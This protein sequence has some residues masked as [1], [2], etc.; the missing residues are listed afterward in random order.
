MHLPSTGSPAGYRR[1][2]A[3]LAELT[4]GKVLTVGYRLAP[5][6]PFPA[7][8]LDVLIAYLSL[9]Y[10]PADSYHESV[11][12]S[13]IVFA[14]D[15]A[16]TCLCLSLV[17]VILAARGK[18]ETETPTVIFHGRRVELLMPS[19]LAFLNLAPDMTGSLPSWSAN[20]SS[21][22]FEDTL[23]ALDHRYPTCELWPAKPP[24][25][26]LYCEVSMLDHP[27]VS[28]IVARS[29]V[30]CP[31]MW[32]A[33]GGGERLADGARFLAQNAAR[34][35][36]AVVWEEYEAMPH[37]WPL[38]FPTWSQSQRCWRNWARACGSFVKGAPAAPKGN[39]MEV[40]SLQSRE[41]DILAL[42][43]LSMDE[44]LGYIRKHQNDVK[45]FTGERN[46]AML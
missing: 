25:G 18:Q 16:G 2:V 36:V 37:L 7:A 1:V 6:N 43:R 26:A 21:D 28:P 15:S 23:P 34:Q 19:G 35:G 22:I 8:L 13:N 44:V 38:L 4:H 32:I 27:M 14:G 41:V 10:P 40:G 3:K 30:G 45:P 17:Q 46:K 39:R 12:P 5:Q 20:A 42:T 31:P 33:I 9:L 11:T 24:R 29:W